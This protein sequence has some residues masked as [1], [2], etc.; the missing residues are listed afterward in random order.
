M[1]TRNKRVYYIV[2]LT[3]FSID[4]GLAAVQVE[5]GGTHDATII[6]RGAMRIQIG[7]EEKGRIGRVSTEV[8]ILLDVVLVRLGPRVDVDGALDGGIAKTGADNGLVLRLEAKTHVGCTLKRTGRVPL[9][10]RRE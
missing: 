8:V 5:N 3:I 6:G 4:V 2:V 1:S 10:V 9:E 7:E